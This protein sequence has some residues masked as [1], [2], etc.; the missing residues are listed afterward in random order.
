MRLITGE[1]LIIAAV[2][3]G[4]FQCV[5]PK[6]SE[7][8]V[9]YWKKAFFWDDRGL[10]Y[11]GCDPVVTSNW[12]LAGL[13]RLLQTLSNR[14]LVW[15]WF[16]RVGCLVGFWWSL[17][18]SMI[19]TRVFYFHPSLSLKKWMM[20]L[21]VVWRS[22][23]HVGW[24]RSTIR[25]I[26]PCCDFFGFHPLQCETSD[27]KKLTKS[28]KRREHNWC[29]P[30]III[31]HHQPQTMHHFFREIPQKSYHR[32]CM[33]FGFLPKTG[34]PMKWPA[35]DL[36]RRVSDGMESVSPWGCQR[37]GNP[38]IFQWMSQLCGQRRQ[39]FGR[40]EICLLFTG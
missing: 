14:V 32:I 28:T 27:S 19:K 10:G 15:L 11:G 9:S 23:S 6:H 20:F 39:T 4:Y 21:E 18:L 3:S 26:N 2:Q 37:G 40:R 8:R 35:V 33:K 30:G 31:W 5:L 38:A 36:E 34:I 7:S 29:S 16:D 17:I 24:W 25:F 22:V 12:S 1:K 13:G